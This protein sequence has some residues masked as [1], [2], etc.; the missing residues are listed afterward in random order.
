MR[1]QTSRHGATTLI[2]AGVILCVTLIA[3]V[4]AIVSG[5]ELFLPMEELVSAKWYSSQSSFHGTAQGF[6]AVQARIADGWHINSHEP[7]DEYLIPTVL[8]ISP[9]AGIEIVRILY[10]EPIMER[11]DVGEGTMSLYGGTVTF[12]VEIRLDKEIALGSYPLTATLEYQAC[13]NVSCIEPRSLTVETTIT[14]G[15]FKGAV[16]LLHPEIFTNPPFVGGEPGATAG[17]EVE[18]GGLIA[19]RG[20]FLTFLLIFVGG[21]ALNLTPCIYPIIPITVS[22]FAGQAGGR[23]SRTFLLALTYVLGMSI[24]YSVLGIIASTTLG[25]FGAALQNP[26]VIAFIAAV[27]VGLA[28]SMFGLWEIRMPTFL[29][30][31]TGSARQGFIG[32]LFMG[33][34]VGIVAAPCIGPF[35]IGLLTYVGELGNPLLGFSMFFTLAWGMGVP[36]LVLGTV[37]GSLSRLPRSGDWM[38]W[39]RKIFGF[40]LIAMA[41]YFA[42]HIIGRIPTLIGYAAVALIGG[43]YLGWRDR[44]AGSGR[45]FEIIRKVIG[46][47]G[48]AIALFMIAGPSGVRPWHEKQGGIEWLAYSEEKLATARSEG[49]P[50][51]IDFWAE[52]CVP[53]HKLDRKTFSD[54]RVMELAKKVV[55]IKADLTLRGDIEKKIKK[56]FGIRGVPTIIF[57]DKSGAEVEG[58]RINGYAGPEVLIDR[59]KRL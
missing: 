36:F 25:L 57:L 28:T 42:R 9:P 59:L 50:V 54:P 53:C 6:L 29:M 21:L 19:E 33:L 18:I 35:V 27:L 1:I 38:I 16:D 58:S 14:V 7:L 39:V 31:R 43:I 26:W 13:N 41:V 49:K 46:I 15:E 12:G 20:L 47:A 56:D 8:E 51:M 55:T 52:W 2:G 37:S 4:F 3:G 40:I 10:P 17:D 11:L 45:R 22:F 23:I 32:A 30:R 5:Q 34:T 48:I 44:P 24:T